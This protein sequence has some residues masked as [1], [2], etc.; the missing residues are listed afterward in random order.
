MSNQVRRNISIPEHT[1]EV[2]KDVSRRGGVASMYLASLLDQHITT[3]EKAL[4]ALADVAR[5]YPKQSTGAGPLSVLGR[6]I[7]LWSEDGELWNSPGGQFNWTLVQQKD[8]ALY[9]D[10]RQH[11]LVSMSGAWSPDLK[12]KFSYLV[13]SLAFDVV[14]MDKLQAAIKKDE[15]PFALG[16][17]PFSLANRKDDNT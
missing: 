3:R 5:Y 17:D 14:L 13:Q 16:A 2:L 1:D 9:E 7:V 11:D 8:A 15:N 4:F 10:A 6:L 12:A